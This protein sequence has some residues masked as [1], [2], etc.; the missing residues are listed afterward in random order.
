MTSAAV[1][2]SLIEFLRHPRPLQRDPGPGSERLSLTLPAES[3]RRA[4]NYLCC[5]SSAILRM[6]AQD[7]ILPPPSVRAAQ[8]MVEQRGHAEALCKTQISPESEQPPAPVTTRNL[9]ELVVSVCVT[10]LSIVFWIVL[11]SRRGKPK[12]ANMTT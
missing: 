4:A 10:I 11:S 12:T 7:S 8:M 5:S 2:G 1:R 6:L 3:V 9:G